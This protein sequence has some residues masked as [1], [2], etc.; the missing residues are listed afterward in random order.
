[1]F[2]RLA[3]DMESLAS[4]FKPAGTLVGINLV[5]EKR[6]SMLNRVYKGRRG[7]AEI[8][9]FDYRDEVQDGQQGDDPSGE[10]YLCWK[11]LSASAARKKVTRRAYALRLIAHGL[12]HLQG[13]SHGD[14]VSAGRMEKAEM[15][16]LDRI[17]TAAEIDRLFDRPKRNG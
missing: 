16:Y 7:C 11:R 4:L 12:C 3:R 17:V 8:L 15:R 13:Y 2:D 5:G 1:E 14:D 10:I 6:M 9:T